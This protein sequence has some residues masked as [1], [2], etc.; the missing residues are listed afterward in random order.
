M[1]LT[2]PTPTPPSPKRLAG[3]RRPILRVLAA[4]AIAGL[5]LS[6]AFVSLMPA[7]HAGAVAPVQDPVK[8]EWSAR[9]GA[10]SQLNSLGGLPDPGVAIHQ[11]TAASTQALG[12]AGQPISA[13]LADAKAQLDAALRAGAA[14]PANYVPGM[15]VGAFVKVAKPAAFPLPAFGGKLDVGALRTVAVQVD[16]SPVVER[17]FRVPTMGL[18]QAEALAGQLTL[19]YAMLEKTLDGLNASAVTGAIPGGL[20]LPVALPGLG[21]PQARDA[22][23]A[24]DPDEQG[25]L[26]A[27]DHAGALLKSVESA[28]AVS[29]PSLASLLSGYQGL[30][31]QVQALVD[32]A[33]NATA[34]AQEG[35]Q[36]Q[37][38]ARIEGLRQAVDGAQ[39]KAL[40]TVAA[41]RAA[42]EAAVQDAQAALRQ[43]LDAQ[44]AAVQGAVQSDVQRLNALAAQLPDVADAARQKIQSTV[45]IAVANL[46]R[47]QGMD[48]AASV[49]AVQAAGARA[50]QKVMQDTLA[51]GQALK[52][53]AAEVQAR[54]EAAVRQLTQ[55]ATTALATL[56]GTATKALA[57]ADDLQTYLTD[58]ALAQATAAEAAET[59]AAQAAL[60]Q[61]LKLEKEQV[62]KV[63]KMG[64]QLAGSSDAA[65][66]SVGDLVDKVGTT[67][68][69]EVQK[70]IGYVAKVSGDYAKVPTSQ[71]ME[72]ANAWSTVANLAGGRLD[73]VL[74]TTD[75][76]ADL[77]DQ[78]VAAARSAKAQIQGM[79]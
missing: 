6:G 16:P 65:L 1:P 49:Q 31:G 77:A 63:T 11:A 9:S 24:A 18:E 4:V 28:Y 68:S 71:R 22:S 62:A 59:A 46:S 19:A 7:G 58:L 70:D 15:D 14:L 17:G 78:V 39:K 33:H 69:A 20:P 47:V 61:L 29:Q 67:A 25:A 41:Q 36:A 60:D 34:K 37:L 79:A 27:G 76:L 73:K 44:V 57:K 32:A 8:Q 2:P 10:L 45:D 56:Q 35:V 50:L 13:A 64:L 3:S 40:D 12:E 23:N 26:H 75:A 51:H 54:G 66:K 74:S 42:I 52:D 30:A 48:T 72:R 5:A 38:Q 53:A 21:G 55:Q 43:A